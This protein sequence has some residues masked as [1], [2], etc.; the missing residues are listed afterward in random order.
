MVLGL[1]DGRDAARVLR[2]VERPVVEADREGAE[3]GHVPPREHRDGRRIEP[4]GKEDAQRHVRE[5]V[6]AYGEVEHG[7]QPR[8]GLHLHRR[9]AVVIAHVPPALDTRLAARV[10][11]PVA[12][13]Q[14]AHALHDRARRRHPI[15]GEIG[16]HRLHVELARD[17]RML[18]HR[19]QLGGE[20]EAVGE[21]RIVE[22]LDAQP[23]PRQHQRA[24]GVVPD[25]EPEHPL[26]VVERVG[27]ARLPRVHDRLGVRARAEHVTG[28]R[29]PPRQLA[30]VVDFA[31]ERDPH[32]PVLAGHRLAAAL[33]VDDPETAHAERD[34]TAHHEALVVGT[35]VGDAIG[36][37]LD[38]GLIGPAVRPRKHDADDAAHDRYS[39]PCMPSVSRT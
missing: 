9:L 28:R 20:D 2:L 10:G 16:G 3:A 22:R 35:A 15:V 39:T 8:R 11:Q 37:A 1:E 18:E 31:V 38:D 21:H 13:R 4:A 36:H 14:L 5:Q 34:G 33:E 32:G 30:V 25:G 27:A 26:E 6:L 24:R 7:A 12:R 29:Q 23:I 19:L 17:A